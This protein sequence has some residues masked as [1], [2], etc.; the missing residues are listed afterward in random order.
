MINKVMDYKDVRL[1]AR[2]PETGMKIR[3]IPID[4]IKGYNYA[5]QEVLAIIEEAKG[6]KA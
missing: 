2:F 4:W 1:P 5:I 6:G 3:V